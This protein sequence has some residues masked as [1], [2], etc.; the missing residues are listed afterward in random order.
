MEASKQVEILYALLTL[1]NNYWTAF[2]NWQPD[3]P[4][5]LQNN[6]GYL[7]SMTPHGA[8]I[9]RRPPI[10]QRYGESVNEPHRQMY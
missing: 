3:N 6:Q 8:T 10:N 4:I 2:Y 5:M 1:D 7:G 9:K